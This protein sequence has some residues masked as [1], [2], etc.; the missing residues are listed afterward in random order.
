MTLIYKTAVT[1]PRSQVV[2]SEV[3][4]AFAALP[5]DQQT[6][7]DATS[8][9][10]A[11]L[12]SEEREQREKEVSALRERIAELEGKVS[13]LTALIENKA[14]IDLPRWLKKHVA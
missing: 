1:P 5:V 10:M 6:M 9:A 14:A 3:E 11:A 2:D 8:L 12:A 7:I 13:V 4:E